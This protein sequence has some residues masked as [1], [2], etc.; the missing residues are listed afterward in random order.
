MARRP[1]KPTTPPESAAPGWQREQEEKIALIEERERERERRLSFTP[2]VG[3]TASGARNFDPGS[4]SRFRKLR[5]L[6]R[7]LLLA[8]YLLLGLVIAG[9]GITIWQWRVG[10]IE[11][12]DRLAVTLV[13]WLVAGGFIYTLFKFLG[14]LAWL[15]A[16]LGD[17]QSDVRNLLLDLRDDLQRHW[18]AEERR[19]E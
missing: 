11:G 12:V 5:A 2:Q 16:D 6:S 19:R 10:E 4:P 3:S 13:I 15:L 7:F 18:S 9:V 1:K 8:S 17:H 14:E